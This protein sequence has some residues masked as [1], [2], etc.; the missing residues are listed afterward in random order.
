MGKAMG[1]MVCVAMLAGAA[2]G[3]VLFSDD[4]EGYPNEAALDSPGAWGDDGVVGGILLTS[5]GNP[6]QYMV[7][8]G[9][10]AG[11]AYHVFPAYTPSDA[12]PLVWEFDLLDRE[13]SD[14]G[15]ENATR[16]TGGLRDNGGGAPLAALLEMGIYNAAQ[17]L[18]TGLNENNYALRHVF[19]G[20]APA[21]SG[22]WIAF[23]GVT[24]TIGSWNHFRATIG[25]TS[26]L[27][28]LDLGDNGTYDSSVLVATTAS[29]KPYNI[30]RFGGPSGVTSGTSGGGFTGFAGTDNWN[31]QKVPEPAALALLGLGGLML[32]RRRRRA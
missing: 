17:N 22:G 23:P 18:T 2:Q 8:Q 7:S 11:N 24:R 31:I 29:A 21:G 20:G 27:F 5:G 9:G 4:F 15:G 14:V 6:G 26:I 12:M 19:V 3:Q 13:N 25:A 30:G 10:G 1:V 32:V 16:I 28:E